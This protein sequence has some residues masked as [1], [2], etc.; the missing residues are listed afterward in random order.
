MSF[1]G[2]K[3][4]FIK[5]VGGENVDNFTGEVALYLASTNEPV[6]EINGKPITFNVMDPEGIKM[7]MKIV[8]DKLMTWA[9]KSD[10]DYYINNVNLADFVINK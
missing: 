8:G 3:K 4:M 7:G 1:G 9:E 5:Q 10:F 6:A 2:D